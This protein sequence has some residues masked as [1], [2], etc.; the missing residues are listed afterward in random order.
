MS[1]YEEYA[2]IVREINELEAKR[3][4]LGIVLLEKLRSE[5]KDAVVTDQGT[6]SI[7]T[8][9]TWTYSEDIK[10]LEE[11]LKQVKSMEQES[12]KAESKEKTVFRFKSV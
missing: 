7:Y 9:R 10:K 4:V 1:I 8:H 3:E 11:S 2:G 12:G 5:N 6:Y